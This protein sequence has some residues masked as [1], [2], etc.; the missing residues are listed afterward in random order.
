MTRATFTILFVCTGNICRS[1]I[2]EVLTRHLLHKGLGAGVTRFSVASAGTAAID[3]ARMDPHS[4][5]ALTVRGLDHDAAAFRARRLDHAM[6]ADADLVLT[7]ERFHRRCVVL[8]EPSAL[9]TTFAFREIVRLLDG[10]NPD[11]LPADPVER[12]R[13]T[14]DLARQRR[15]WDGYVSADADAVPD[16]FALAPGT[17]DSSADMIH[18]TSFRLVE[19]LSRPGVPRTSN[20]SAGQL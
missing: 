5:A 2:A 14:V 16:P 8:L 9:A 3:G 18:A 13:A 1:P 6:I 17:H 19:L 20:Y 12:A 11:A 15:G 7:A 10:A 4:R